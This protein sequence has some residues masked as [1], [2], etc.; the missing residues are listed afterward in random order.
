MTRGA[1]VES[2]AIES[3][4]D[5]VKNTGSSLRILVVDDNDDAASTLA[6][7]LEHSGHQAQVVHDGFA[8]LEQVSDQVPD[9]VILDIG[10]PLMNGYD[11]CRRIRSYSA[12]RQ[13]LIIALTGWGQDSDRK[14]SKAAGFDAHLVKPIDYAKLVALLPECHLDALGPATKVV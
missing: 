13:P 8:A 5:L 1:E 3:R 4:H 6:T 14:E 7:L 11:I 9:V 2:P 12:I 10:L